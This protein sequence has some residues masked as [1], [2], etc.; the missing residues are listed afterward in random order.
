MSGY[1]YL[2][3]YDGPPDPHTHMN[4]ISWSSSL[5]LFAQTINRDRRDKH[6]PELP[7]LFRTTHG[8]RKA[9]ERKSNGGLLTGIQ[10]DA[11]LLVLIHGAADGSVVGGH[12][13]TRMDRNN[14][15][16]KRKVYVPDELATHLEKE[17]LPKNHQELRLVSCFGGVG[18]NGD[19]MGSFAERFHAAMQG[20]GYDSIRLT[21][22]LGEV[23]VLHAFGPYDF[24]MA[25]F[26]GNNPAPVRASDQRAWVR[27]I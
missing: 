19:A 24:D 15:E 13:V 10:T 11:E 9:R 7:I 27:I 22:H 18:V 12:Y 20:I 17:G 25:V 6:L 2:P 4:P 14:R 8:F 26:Q 1:I 16:T 3:V 23:K 5:Y 21:A